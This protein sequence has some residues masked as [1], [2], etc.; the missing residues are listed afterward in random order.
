MYKLSER[1]FLQT[2]VKAYGT[3]MKSYAHLNFYAATTGSRRVLV[4][5]EFSSDAVVE[6]ERH[7]WTL[8]S[9]KILTRNYHGI[10]LVLYLPS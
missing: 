4:F 1:L 3:T 9:C 5:A 7:E 2:F 8:S 10:T 6:N